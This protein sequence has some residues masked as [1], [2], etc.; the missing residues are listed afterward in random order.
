ML[1]LI[2]VNSND[3]DRVLSATAD[4]NSCLNSINGRISTKLLRSHYL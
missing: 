1:I 3:L 2:G 4:L